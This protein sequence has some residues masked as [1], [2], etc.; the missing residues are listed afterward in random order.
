MKEI[1]LSI[2]NKIK[3]LQVRE[4]EYADDENLRGMAN[5]DRAISHYLKDY[6]EDERAELLNCIYWVNDNCVKDLEESGWK[7]LRGV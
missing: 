6:N 3:H 7:V 5:C 2:V 1:K 4:F